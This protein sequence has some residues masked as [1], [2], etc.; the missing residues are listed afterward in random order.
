MT[1]AGLPPIPASLGTVVLKTKKWKA[2]AKRLKEFFIFF[3]SGFT[4]NGIA[5]WRLIILQKRVTKNSVKEKIVVRS[6]PMQGSAARLA[7]TVPGLMTILS[8][9][10]IK[11][12]PWA[13]FR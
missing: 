6:H 2:I 4:I 1:K 12:G 3:P 10:N 5:L 7:F 13:A 11:T 8:S 9:I